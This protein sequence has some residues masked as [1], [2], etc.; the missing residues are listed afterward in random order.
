MAFRFSLDDVAYLTSATGERA[1]AA[2]AALQLDDASWLSDLSLLRGTLAE[3]AGAVA[4]TVRLRRRA[5][6]RLGPAAGKLGAAAAD[7]LLTDEALQ[8]ASPARVAAHRAARLADRSVH[9]VTCSIGAD[10][11][12]LAAVGPLAVGSDIDPVR[13]RMAAHNLACAGL[14]V[15][16]AVADAL[17]PVTRG[18]LAYADPARRDVRGRRITSASTV[19]TVAD[20]DAALSGA[21]GRPP[22]LR[23]PPGL[24]FE[25]LARP[26]EVELVSLD[27]TVRE[28]VLWPPELAVV[29][30][31]AT[32]LRGPPAG[33]EAVTSDEPDDA[34]VGPVGEW[35]VDPD[36]AVVRAHLVRQ[37]A[38]RHG[39]RLLDPHLAYL[40]GARP[41]TGVRSFRVLDAAPYREKTV[42]AWIVRDGIGTLEIKQRGTP[43]APDELRRRLRPALRGPTRMAATLIVARI[44]RAPQAFW[45]RVVEPFRST[46]GGVPPAP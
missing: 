1:L 19:P 15:R 26:G 17:R 11:V 23:V 38:V 18:L 43:L 28:A 12:H 22:V 30:R 40:S 21:S 36:P 13:V 9:D 20:L 4:E 10:L 24:D 8:Q 33:D 39:L 29:A 5:A 3:R 32:V 7:W 27:G 2:T 45:C 6:G 14:P 37:Y 25:A 46:A 34:A 44:G 31:R 41:P 35:I 16:V 42:A